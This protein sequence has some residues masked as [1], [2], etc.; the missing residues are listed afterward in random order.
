M[1]LRL[2]AACATASLA[3]C[4]GKSHP[5]PWTKQP[6]AADEAAAIQAAAA[7]VTSFRAESV[8]DYWL[9]KDRV[10]GTVLV[11]GKP[12]AFVRLNA[13]SPAGDSVMA[14]LACDGTNFT[15]VDFQNNCV[16]TGPCN[17]D[18]IA[19]FLHVSLSPDD[20]LHLA[21]G[22]TPISVMP[23]ILGEVSWDGKQGRERL[24]LA[25][26][27]ADGERVRG[28]QS[29]E[30]DGQRDVLSTAFFLDDDRKQL[31]WRIENKDF[32][33]VKDA[34]GGEF[35]VPG[36][37]RFTSPGQKA[38]LLVEWKEITINLPLDAAKFALVPPEGLPTCGAQ[39]AAAQP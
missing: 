11:M 1:K 31:G 34:S 33:A 17:A 3:A 12:G 26:G 16:L 13:L 22:T 9:G 18:S 28:H 15:L 23:P 24:E 35:R 21:T 39:P 6:T 7:R 10:K 32:R 20:F 2:L 37:S 30:L 27:A 4:G 19:Q 29:I 38:D 8:M 25:N 14:D 36:K 5:A